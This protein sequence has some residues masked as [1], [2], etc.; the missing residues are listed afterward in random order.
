MSPAFSIA[1]SQRFEGNDGAWST[2]KLNVGTPP[3]ML[4]V[5]P[6]TSISYVTLI[7]QTGCINVPVPAC[8]SARGGSPSLFNLSASLTFNRLSALDGSRNFYL[9]FDS[10]LPLGVIGMLPASVGLD[11]VT[12]GPSASN[13]TLTSQLVAGIN[14]ANPWQGVFGL[15]GIMNHVPGL[16]SNYTSILQRLKSADKIPSLFYGYTAGAPYTDRQDFGSLTLGGYDA[17]R[18][19]MSAALSV[20]FSDD[21]FELSVVVDQIKIS[22]GNITRI[23]MG[24][25]ALVDSVIPE[26]WLPGS[27]C[28]QIENAIGLVYDNT[29]QMYLISES[30]QRV[31]R[32]TNLTFTF[33]L[34]SPQNPSA[35]IDIVLPYAAFDLSASYPVAGMKNASSTQRYFPIRRANSTTGYY[36]GR[37]FLQEA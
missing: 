10:E 4:R 23:P 22:N 14:A 36:L 2:F 33:T 15:R 17:A 9:P 8:E 18:V 35:M 19:D 30:Q 3:Q 16:D 7:T 29:T 24:N 1:P 26:I 21:P 6:A 25:V 11:A 28:D 12:I 27:V 34:G 37:T 32:S 31:L 13:L 5:L 20:N